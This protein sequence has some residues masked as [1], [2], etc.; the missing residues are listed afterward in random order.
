MDQALGAALLNSLRRSGFWLILLPLLFAVASFSGSFLL[1][2]RWQASGVIQVG[3]MGNISGGARQHIEPLANALE[4]LRLRPFQDL[5]LRKLG[6][7]T[8]ERN[9]LATLFRRTLFGRAIP[10]TDLVEISVQAHSNA[11][12]VNWVATVIQH[13]QE[14]HAGISD[15][16]VNQLKVRFQTLKQDLDRTSAERKRVVDLALASRS[17]DARPDGAGTAL[18]LVAMLQGV[19]INTL[20]RTLAVMEEQLGPMYTRPTKL[21][22]EIETAENPV[23]PRRAR[24]AFL[25]ILV[26]LVMALGIVLFRSVRAIAAL[27]RN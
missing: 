9:A 23:Y 11:Q 7:P 6:I 20:E 22:F 14:I 13:L 8:D 1:N 3:T 26:G 12:A 25:G 15:P 17:S 27:P 24:A 16:H 2:E 4:R 18:A 5:M 10:G 19:E 21:M